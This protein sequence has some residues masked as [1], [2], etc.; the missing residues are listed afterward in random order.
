MLN[1]RHAPRPPKVEIPE[2]LILG[3][4]PMLRLMV[5]SSPRA[6]ET[7]I[8]AVLTIKGPKRILGRGCGAHICLDHPNVSRKHVGFIASSQG[9]FVEDLQSRNGTKL[10]G[11]RMQRRHQIRR[12][13]VLKVG[14]YGF[15]VISVA[16]ADLLQEVAA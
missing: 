8:G 9:W 4:L 16:R 10:N 15:R 14:E 11:Q 13:D 6:S 1:M 5:V 7:K 12:G 3:D 2:K